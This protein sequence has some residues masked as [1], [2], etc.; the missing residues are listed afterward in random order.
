MKKIILDTNALMAV[1]E[2]NLDIFTEI[3]YCCDFNYK[4]FVLESTVNELE[5]IQLE[6]KLKYKRY[7][8]LALSILNKKIKDGDVNFLEDQKPELSTDDNLVI[9]SKQGALVLTQ[10]LGLKRRL[11]KPYLTIRQKKKIVIVN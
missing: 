4:L 11:T 9:E 6:Q 1:A 5:K 10:D 8:K 2:F 3:N 7:A